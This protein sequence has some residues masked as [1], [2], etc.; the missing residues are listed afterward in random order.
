MIPLTVQTL[1]VSNSNMPSVL[2]MRPDE[3]LNANGNT[4]VVPI[5]I[6]LPEATQL[7]I[8]LEHLVMPRPLTHDLFMNAIAS[9][10]AFIDHVEIY[11]LVDTTFYAKLY[12]RQHERSVVL[13][14]RPSDAIALAIKQDAMVYIDEPILNRAS[15]PYLINDKSRQSLSMRRKSKNFMIMLKHFVQM[16]QNKTNSI[17]LILY[18]RKQQCRASFMTRG[19]FCVCL[20]CLSNLGHQAKLRLQP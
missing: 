13:D 20:C 1:I 19:T 3:P 15:Y 6:G 16:I 5:W 11:D 14:A 10:D 17:T 2:V 18:P 12:L 4:R 8:A 7:G 9:L